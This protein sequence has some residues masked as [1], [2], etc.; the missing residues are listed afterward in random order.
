MADSPGQDKCS[1]LLENYINSVQDSVE[2][3]GNGEDRIKI[4]EDRLE[5]EKAAYAALY[6][7][8]EKER[9]AAATAADEAMAMIS[10]LQE[11][12]ASMEMEMRQY[13]R[14]IEERFTYDEEEMIILQEILLRR[15]REN[16]SLEKELEAYRQMGLRGGDRSNNGKPQVVSDEW[17][18]ALPIMIE[19]HEEVLQNECT[20]SVKKDE[21]SNISSDYL[22][23]PT[24]IGM[25]GGELQAKDTEHDSEPDVLDVHVI[26]DNIEL[27][28][29]ENKTNNNIVSKC[30]KTGNDW[31]S[32][33]V[34]NNEKLK[35]DTEIMKLGERL[36]MIQ[37][38]KG[39]LSIFA[40]N[41]ESERVQLKLLEEI[42]DQVLQTKEMRNTARGA[43]LPPSSAKVSLRKRRCQ[44]ASWESS[45]SS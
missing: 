14:M 23:A 33:C 45:E 17:E 11:E 36:K 27:R 10:R 6:L 29:Q 4:L 7:E 40:E 5:E 12:K 19:R 20:I 28:E 22:L 26:D 1:S 18:R 2:I 41:G 44:S 15:E 9:A 16:H 35:I 31:D 42:T 39:K 30:L 38:E 24:F 25:E 34:N 43:S 21:A 13:Q 32:S 3:H 8:L 37:H